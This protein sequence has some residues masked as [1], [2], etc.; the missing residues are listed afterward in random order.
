MEQQK[1]DVTRRATTGFNTEWLL[2][3]ILS[4]INYVKVTLVATF[5]LLPQQEAAA[6]HV[7]NKLAD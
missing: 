6:G 5:K 4:V 7:A 3:T 2:F 1:P